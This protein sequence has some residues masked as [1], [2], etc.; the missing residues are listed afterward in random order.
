MQACDYFADEQRLSVLC[1]M[2]GCRLFS[3]DLPVPVPLPEPPYTAAVVPSQSPFIAATATIA[4]SSQTAF[5]AAAAAA[6]AATIAPQ[7]QCSLAAA[8]AA[9]PQYMPFGQPR[10]STGDSE[11]T[12]IEAQ[13]RAGLAVHDN[14]PE[15]PAS[16]AATIS[17]H[18]LSFDE[19]CPG[20]VRTVASVKIM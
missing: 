8:A 20:Q 1:T 12:A 13:Q 15:P 3:R 9:A 6:A 2:L 14:D 10:E 19:F 5:S 7:A 17:S 4:G 16:L 18:R 11:L